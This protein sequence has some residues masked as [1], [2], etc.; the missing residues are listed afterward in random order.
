[1]ASANYYDGLNVKLYQA[2]PKTAERVL[3]LGC[4]NGRLGHLFKSEHPTASWYGVDASTAAC[5]QARAVLDHVQCI[6]MDR[7]DDVTHEMNEPF[8]LLVLGDVLE[9]LKMPGETLRALHRR[10]SDDAVLVCCLPNMGHLSVIERLVL[11]DISYDSM[12][13]LDETHLRL[14]SPSSAFKLF[15]DAGWLPDMVDQYRYET[16]GAHPAFAEAILRAAEALGV[17]RSTAMKTLGLYQMIIVCRKRRDLV[18]IESNGKGESPFSVIVPC[19]RPLQFDLN[20]ARSPGILEVGADIVR[21]DG[22]S[23]AADAYT[24]GAARARHAWRLFVHQD[25]YIPEGAGHAIAQRLAV[26]EREGTVAPIGFAGK[27][28]EHERGYA[29]LIVDRTR[30]FDHVPY[31]HR[32]YALDELGVIL[33]ASS[34]LTIDPALGWHLWATDLCYQ[35]EQ[36]VGAPCG[37]VLGVPVFHNSSSDYGIPDSFHDSV[38]A[39]FAKYPERRSITNLCGT[40]ARETYLPAK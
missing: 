38:R 20:I 39:L 30:L 13:L 8:D 2:L 1:M 27:T 15:L 19:N 12:G 18:G 9:H 16:S 28:L 37:K 5:D 21:V 32:A 4:A 23:S 17:P 34:P 35:A 3:E 29:G 14:Y 24:Q 33:H 6:D 40:F 22:A 36:L 26:A 10:S 25:V 31:A 7:H 11:G